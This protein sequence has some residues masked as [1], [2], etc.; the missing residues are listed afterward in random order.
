MN[1]REDARGQVWRWSKEE[2]CIGRIQRDK[3]GMGRPCWMFVMAVRVLRDGVQRWKEALK[4]TGRWRGRGRP[5]RPRPRWEPVF[6]SPFFSSPDFLLFSALL[7][8]D[9]KRCE[10]IVI[11]R[12]IN[13]FL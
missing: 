7:A 5:G 13:H 8:G 4:G 6:S 10:F 9:D 12:T 11:V 3:A 2:R 1:V